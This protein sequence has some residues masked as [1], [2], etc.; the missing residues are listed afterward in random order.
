[1]TTK[2][3]SSRKLPVAD[4]HYQSASYDVCFPFGFADVSFC[5]R[6]DLQNCSLARQRYI[7]ELMRTSIQTR[8]DICTQRFQ[9]FTSDDVFPDSCLNW[10]FKQLSGY[11]V[12]S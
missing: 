10:D 2:T 5:V 6:N 1:M 9:C 7:D 11:N 3:V 12:I 8:R 4:P